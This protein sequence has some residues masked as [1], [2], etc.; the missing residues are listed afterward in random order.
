VHVQADVIGGPRLFDGW[1]E[2]GE[3]RVGRRQDCA[4]VL[5]HPSISRVQATL[6][7][8]AQG[9]RLVNE[10]LSNVVLQDGLP[11]GEGRWQLDEVTYMMGEVLLHVRPVVPPG[12]CLL[13]PEGAGL[14]TEPLVLD[15]SPRV[16]GRS[17]EGVL[18]L[19]HASVSRQHAELRL[20]A[21]GWVVQDLQSANGTTVNG[22]PASSPILLQPGDVISFGDI[23]CRLESVGVPGPA[24]TPSRSMTPPLRTPDT[25]TLA[26]MA[27]TLVCIML[28]LWLLL[29]AQGRG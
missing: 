17:G 21:E 24:P 18:R 12:L 27:G 25:I 26:L 22:Y 20:Q 7:I 29:L 14:G 1:L 15:R 11:V 3:N 4:V 19:R 10:S 13:R 6:H 16:V 5:D 9:A 23:A 8:G 28:L 2:A